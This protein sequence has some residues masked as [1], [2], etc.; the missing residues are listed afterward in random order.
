MS[1]RSGVGQ[2]SLEPV[3][4]GQDLGLTRRDAYLRRCPL[5]GHL[6][7]VHAGYFQPNAS[8][9]LAQHLPA[10]AFRA[11]GEPEAGQFTDRTRR[12]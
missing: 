2:P 9:D 4:R 6:Q 12:D 7:I 1:S 10:E 8:L 3:E 5:I 11:D